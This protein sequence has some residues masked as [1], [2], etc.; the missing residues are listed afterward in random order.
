MPAYGWSA[1]SPA[2]VGPGGPL[3]RR[4]C[5]PTFRWVCPGSALWT[6]AQGK[7][8]APRHRLTPRVRRHTGFVT[9]KRWASA[10]ATICTESDRHHAHYVARLRQLLNDA[11]GNSFIFR[12]FFRTGVQHRL[13]QETVRKWINSNCGVSKDKKKPGAGRASFRARSLSSGGLATARHS[14]THQAETEQRE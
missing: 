13:L 3:A 6:T 9:A 12:V 4:L 11:L 14:K 5:V 1:G 2:S 7:A 8:G 10:G